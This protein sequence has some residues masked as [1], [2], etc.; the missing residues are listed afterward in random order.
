[1]HRLPNHESV[2]RF[3]LAAFWLLC[4]VLLIPVALMLLVYSLL[5]ERR[6]ITHGALGMVAAAVL[7][8]IIQWL[9]A[10]RARCPLCLGHPLAN[11]AC[12]THRS[13]RRIL[14]SYRLGVAFTVVFRGF[15][16]CPYCG[17]TTSIEVRRH[18]H[19][20]DFEH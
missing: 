2:T 9:T 8:S 3:R 15:F 13:V 7:I 19:H 18:R 1:M 17:E 5:V 10:A 16:R 14:G 6:D 20:R 4:N 12:V 11:K